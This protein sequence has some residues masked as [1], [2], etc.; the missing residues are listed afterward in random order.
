VKCVFALEIPYLG[1]REFKTS[2]IPRKDNRRLEGDE[3]FDRRS[4]K[5]E[6]GKNWRE[7]LTCCLKSGQQEDNGDHATRER[8]VLGESF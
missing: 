3:G 5:R 4:A 6:G 8:L 2:R 1:V 7:M